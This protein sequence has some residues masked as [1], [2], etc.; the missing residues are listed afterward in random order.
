MKDILTINQLEAQ[1]IRRAER[2][3]YL[4]KTGAPEAAIRQAEKDLLLTRRR[5]ERAREADYDEE[6]ESVEH[7][8]A[9]D[10]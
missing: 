6:I 5:L 1:R 4:K 8:G 7:M 9:T 2:I 10:K 3:E